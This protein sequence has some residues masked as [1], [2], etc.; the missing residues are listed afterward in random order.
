MSRNLILRVGRSMSRSMQAPRLVA[1]R[2]PMRMFSTA[3]EIMVNVPSMGDSISEGTVVSLKN[4]G[5]YVHADEAVV[6]LETDKVSVDVN[7][8]HGGLITS[9]LA[10]IDDVVNV[11][12]PLFTLDKAAP[13]PITK[14][15]PAAAAPVAPTP[16]AAPATPAAAAAKAP[17]PKKPETVAVP[18]PTAAP[19]AG[20][21]NRT[22]TRVKMSHLHLR[23]NQRMKDTQDTAAVLTTFQEVDIGNLMALQKELGET[24]EKTHK[25]KLGFL[26]AFVKAS[27][28]A[29]QKVPAINASIDDE[30]K[31]I[32]YHEYA[33]INV[34]VATEKG[35]TTPVLRNVESLSMADIERSLTDL[36]AKAEEG[37]L[38]IEDMAGGT[39]SIANGAVQGSLLSTSILHAPQSA[40]MSLH[41]IQNR[42]VYHDGKVV[43]RPMMYIS[44]SYDHRLIDGREGVTFLKTVADAVSDP[45][46][47]LLEI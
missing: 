4:V 17:A 12:A 8:P 27:A 36:G 39:F 19:V 42:A 30:A 32:V 44:L 24:F 35:V 37:S 10:S 21:F 16:A 20:K 1:G 34:V 28:M 6:V 18:A 11:G 31:D 9:I 14:A 46:R 26:S 15:A 23:S 7:A 33:D 43:S 45:R 13:A 22:E 38:A 40:I 29:L 3:D 25:V 5:D 2:A 47:L 41:G